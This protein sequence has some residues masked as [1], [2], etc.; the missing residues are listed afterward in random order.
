MSRKISGEVVLFSV[1][2]IV[3]ATLVD[4]VFYLIGGLQEVLHVM[5]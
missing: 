5:V 4:A 3:S 1:I 2:S